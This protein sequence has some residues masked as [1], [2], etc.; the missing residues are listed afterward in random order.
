MPPEQEQQQ[1]TPE[2]FASQVK[3]KYPVYKDWPT[4]HLVNEVVTK[5]PE[6]KSWVKAAPVTPQTSEQKAELQ[7]KLGTETEFEKENKPSFFG[8]AVRTAAK[9]PLKTAGFDTNSQS[10]ALDWLKAQGQNLIGLVTRPKEGGA[11]ETLGNIVHQMDDTSHEGAV[12]GK[13]GRSVEPAEPTTPGAMQSRKGGPVF[14]LGEELSHPQLASAVRTAASMI[15]IVGPGAVHSGHEIA[16]ASTP[17]EMGEGIADAGGTLGQAALATKGGQKFA[18]NAMKAAR[19]P[20][21]AEGLTKLGKAAVKK[22]GEPYTAG[23]TGEEM[24][25]KG[26]A[27]YAKQTG[28]DAALKRTGQDIAEYHRE[29]PINSVKDFHAAVG[30]IGD[31]ILNDEMKPAAARHATESLAP[32]RMARVQAAVEESI[33]PHVEEFEPAK[34]EE[35][36]EFAKK[37]GKARTVGDIIGGNKGGLLGYVNGKLDSYFAKYPSARRADLMKNPDTAAWEGARRALREEVMQ[38]LEE[39]GEAGVREARQRWGALQELDKALERR[40]NVNDRAK[41]M[42]LPRIMG[43]VG[44]PFTGGLSVIAGEVAHH[45]NKPDVLVRRGIGKMSKQAMEAA[46]AA[47]AP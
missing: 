13:T 43:L 5:H 45:L 30:E 41:P 28:F 36:K 11:P 4:E 33:G 46:R 39:K 47:S 37:M 31:K 8:E 10:P 16:R 12:I 21:A 23:L 24:V 22:I 2:E 6:Y 29:T 20:E 42:S 34:A 7:K 9:I 17:Q 19:V 44:A 14:R 3:A 40:V 32:E 1:Y 15:P 38:H 25:K 26:V 35:L 27:P 18:E